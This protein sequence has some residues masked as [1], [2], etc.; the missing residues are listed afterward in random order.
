MLK[1][2][3]KRGRH[4]R[5]GDRYV[6]L[7]DKVEDENRSSKITVKCSKSS[8][9]NPISQVTTRE[10]KR[11]MS[12]SV[13]SAIESRVKL[14]DKREDGKKS[15]IITVKCS[16]TKNGKRSFFRWTISSTGNLGHRDFLTI[17]RWGKT[18]LN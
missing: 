2:P 13:H 9:S 10:N 4:T 15:S 7:K 14:K 17:P 3:N 12:E 8:V 1:V 11:K 18:L 5:R 16:N 6:K